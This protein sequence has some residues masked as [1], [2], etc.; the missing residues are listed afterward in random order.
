MLL[1]FDFLM[2]FARF[3]HLGYYGTHMGGI[4]PFLF[5]FGAMILFLIVRRG[6]GY[7]R[8]GTGYYRPYRPCPPNYRWG[9]PY[10]GAYPRSNEAPAPEQ[11]PGRSSPYDRYAGQYTAQSGNY[12]GAPPTVAN[13]SYGAPVPTPDPGQPTVRVD[14]AGVQSPGQPQPTV[15]VDLPA[16]TMRIDS[17]E[18]GTGGHPT[19]PLGNIPQPPAE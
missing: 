11:N 14:S 8:R 10:Q 3:G 5:F 17:S 2:Q 4:S 12:Y 18:T 1:N 9:H 6:A 19:T 16:T 15:R 13:G 7:N